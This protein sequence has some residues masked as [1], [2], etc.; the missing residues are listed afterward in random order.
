[1]LLGEAPRVAPAAVPVASARMPERP[2]QRPSEEDR[3][4]RWRAIAD[5]VNAGRYERGRRQLDELI[6][7]Y[8]DDEQAHDLLDRLEEHEAA[9]ED[10]ED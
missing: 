1:M 4:R 10:Y 3:R 7:R 6:A 5:D 2:A 8:P 9:R